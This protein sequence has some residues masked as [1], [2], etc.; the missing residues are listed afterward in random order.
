M[1]EMQMSSE[2]RRFSRVPFTVKVEVTV[3]KETYSS[4]IIDNLSV[5]GCLLP[6]LADLKPQKTCFMKILLSE[7]DDG[8]VIK[9][10]GKIIRCSSGTAAIKFTGIDPD[11]LFHLQ[12]IIRYNYPDSDQVEKEINDH[13]GLV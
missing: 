5:G 9:V 2:K 13:P 11:S 6:L 1:E 3:G 10:E 7:T 4:D 12:N 8:P